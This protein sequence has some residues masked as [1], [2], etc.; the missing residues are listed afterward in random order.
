MKQRTALA[1]RTTGVATAAAVALL[2][3]AGMTI[4]AIAPAGATTTAI[5]PTST[6]GWT[7]VTDACT[8]AA[9]TATQGFETGPATPPSGTGS[10]ELA[11]GTNGDSQAAMGLQDF[12]GVAIDDIDVFRYS[13]YVDSGSGDQA[14]YV[15]IDMDLDGD[16]ATDEQLVFEPLYQTAGYGNPPQGPIVLDTWQT[17]D[18]A[19]GGSTI[20]NPTPGTFSFQ[21]YADAN[22][23]A[24]VASDNAAGGIRITAGCGAPV[25]ANFV[26]NIDLVTIQ[27]TGQPTQKY[28]FEATAPARALTVT[29]TSGPKGTV[30]TVSGTDCFEP[31]AT[32]GMGQSYGES[33]DNLATTT[34]TPGADGRF[35]G[36]LT[37]PNEADAGATQSVYASCGP[38][39]DEAFTYANQPFDVTGQPNPTGT[40][41][42]RMVAA[43]GGIFTFGAR[44]FHG[45][46][47]DLVLNKPIVGGATDKGTYNGYWIVASDGGVFTFNVP[48]YGSLGDQKLTAPATE[49]EPTPTGKGYWIVTADGKVYTFGDANH[50]GDMAGKALN[51]SIIGMSVTP[52]GKGYW[53]VAEDGGIFNFGDAGF[54][55][56]TGAM[57]LNAPVIDL[58]PAVDNNGYYLLAK[59]GG[60]FTFGSADFKGSTG[61]LKLNAPV[62]AMLVSPTGSGYWLAATDGGIFTFG[63]VDFLGSMGGTKLNSPVLDLI[64]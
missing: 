54:F 11:T 10:Y 17:W 49:I 23:G 22:P 42:Y 45:S 35:S 3:S 7:A 43:D 6:A 21:E 61:D 39:A 55:G 63:A 59:D 53:L 18:V 36:T 20:N 38:T 26:G 16:G 62:I 48:F 52:T 64:N 31:T 14:P 8:A 51:K 58:A 28:D 33:G 1:R 40:N 46:T 57:K 19:N 30:V 60:V 2:A 5:T 27:E 13:T 12:D 37:V 9:T 44:T 32:I 50:F 47:G 25:W 15:V 24:E 29:P 4:G 34:V 56:S 41:G